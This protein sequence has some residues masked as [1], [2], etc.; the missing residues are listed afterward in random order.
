VVYLSAMDTKLLNDIGM[1]AGTLTD[2]AKEPS[3]A[4]T[5]HVLTLLGSSDRR[6]RS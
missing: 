3:S 1:D 2:L 6:K 4:D 5:T